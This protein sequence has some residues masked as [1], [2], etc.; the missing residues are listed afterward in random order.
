MDAK[1]YCNPLS[2]P[3]YPRGMSTYEASTWGGWI[4]LE[5]RDFRE[6]ADPSVLYHDG[7]WYL[8][9]SCGMAYVSEDFV[10]WRHHRLEPYNPG[11]APTILH[12]HDAFYLTACGAPLY[13][14]DHPLGPFREVGPFRQ[15]D[16]TKLE[17]W[18]DP[19]L[20]ADDDGRVYA[21][22]GIGKPGI[23]GAELS[24]DDLSQM[25]TEPEILF[26]F[27]PA[28]W[29]ERFGDFHEDLNT[30]YNEGPWM[31]KH[32]GRYYLTYATP[33]TQWRT[34]CMAAYIAESPLGPFRPQPRN[35]VLYDDHGL[36]T[37]PGHGCLV[38][39]PGETL[40]AF[41]T[42]VVRNRHIFER[43]I[44]M[45]PA[46]FDADGNLMVPGGASEIPGWAPGVLPHPEAGN[47]AGLLP[48][49]VNKPVRASS[50]I[51]GRDAAY[52]VDNIMQT[53]WQ[54][55]DADV[56]PWLEIN[57]ESTFLVAAARI[58]WQDEGLDYAAGIVPGPFRYLIEG[59]AAAGEWMVLC[60]R[61]AGDEDLLVDYQVFKEACIDTV[62]F[63]VV[64]WPQ[65]I[66]PALVGL[67]VF[68]RSAPPTD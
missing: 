22:W 65:G 25:I 32:H 45:D 57:L 49:T 43:R 18:V 2:L 7:A 42:C 50:E 61:S 24:R 36:I 10:T 67:T 3:D 47:D 40:W 54:P 58:L 20:F 13:R 68:G 48:V 63:S 1:T 12:C 29:W 27:N 23:S 11:Y 9:S 33:G 31:I 14:A 4:G 37:G 60:D 46:G 30:N 62:R 17:G 59:K 38:R 34:Y 39:G 55:V 56:R 26:Q 6:T 21:Y 8:Y 35:P 44:G 15:P 51:P 53:W 64:G 66:H 52:A 28:H 16:G 41:Y 5:K 19:M